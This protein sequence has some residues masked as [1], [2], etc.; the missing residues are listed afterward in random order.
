M[1]IHVKKSLHKYTLTASIGINGASS[2]QVLLI[3]C[4]SLSTNYKCECL[5]E[6]TWLGDFLVWSIQVRVNIITPQYS[7]ETSEFAKSHW[8]HWWRTEQVRLVW[9]EKAAFYLK[10]MAAQRRF[11]KPST[12][13]VESLC[14]SLHFVCAPITLLGEHCWRLLLG[15]INGKRLITWTIMKINK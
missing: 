12:R 6:S 9:K 13:L 2:S 4:T 1:Y 5:C 7:H 10:S 3:K 8:T 14:V 15:E 11:S